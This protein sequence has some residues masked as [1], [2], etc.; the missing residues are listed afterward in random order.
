MYGFQKF[1]K[2]RKT[3]LHFLKLRKYLKN[4]YCK[5]QI[6]NMF[7]MLINQFQRVFYKTSVKHN[8]LMKMIGINFKLVVQK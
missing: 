4:V 6:K 8:S 3:L 7:Y 2:H 1:Y 5:L